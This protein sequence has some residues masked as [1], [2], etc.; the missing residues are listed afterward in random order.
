MDCCFN[1]MIPKS[2]GGCAVLRPVSKTWVNGLS[3]SYDEQYPPML[4]GRIETV[5]FKQTISEINDALFDYWPCFFCFGFGY[6]FCL[7]TLGLSFCPALVCVRDA[8]GHVEG[9]LE[10]INVRFRGRGITWDLIVRHSTSWIEIR[11]KDNLISI[12]S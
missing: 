5:E 9:V 4:E 6:F 12:Y 3:S 2:D 10:D 11:V 7:C 1:R 8:R